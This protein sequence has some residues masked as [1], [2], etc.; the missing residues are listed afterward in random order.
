MA[1]TYLTVLSSLRLPQAFA[2]AIRSDLALIGS[3][4]AEVELTTCYWS[5]EYCDCKALAIVHHLESE[6]E[7]CSRHFR[8]VDKREVRL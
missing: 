2:H 6:L 8:M 3:V 4:S 7:F 5:D 1:V